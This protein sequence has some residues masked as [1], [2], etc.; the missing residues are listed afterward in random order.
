MHLCNVW[1]YVFDGSGYR[2]TNP[3]SINYYYSPDRKGAHSVDHL[4]N[5]SGLMHVDGYGGY[6]KLYGNQIIETACMAHVCR[7][8]HDVIKLKPSPIAEEAL[9]CI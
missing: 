7:K 3:G 5:F 1:V 6:K 9:A 8:F 4:A 2:D